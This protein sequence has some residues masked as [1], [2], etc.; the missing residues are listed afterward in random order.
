MGIKHSISFLCRNGESDPTNL[1][2]PMALSVCR[3]Y[4]LQSREGQSK[5]G[6][7]LVSPLSCEI[8]KMF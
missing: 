2:L 5:D 4:K 6:I 3:S 1:A 7:A 8:E